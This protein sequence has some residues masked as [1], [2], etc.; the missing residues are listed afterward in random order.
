[1]MPT[2]KRE[3]IICPL[4]IPTVTS[5]DDTQTHQ[6]TAPLLT[7]NVRLNECFPSQLYKELFTTILYII[8][9]DSMVSS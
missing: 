3:T 6:N 5:A 9:G 4:K 7:V 8:I 1:M 2:N